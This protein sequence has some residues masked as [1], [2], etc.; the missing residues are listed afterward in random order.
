MKKEKKKLTRTTK[1]TPAGLTRKSPKNKQTHRQTGKENNQSDE[2]EDK[3]GKTE[4]K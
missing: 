4:K 2:Q 3:E 1:R